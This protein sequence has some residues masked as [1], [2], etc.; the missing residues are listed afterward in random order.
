MLKIKVKI[1][2][3]QIEKGGNTFLKILVILVMKIYT[4]YILVYYK[5]F[6]VKI[7]EMK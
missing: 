7:L 1:I 5:F 4:H 3:L 2:K 6:K